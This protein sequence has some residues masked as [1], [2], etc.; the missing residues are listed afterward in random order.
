MKHRLT[1]L[2]ALAL[3]FSTAHADPARKYLDIPAQPLASA[4]DS[5]AKQSGLQMLFDR[6][7]LAGK[8]SAALRG[9][10]T[11]VEAARKLLAGS[12]LVVEQTGDEAVSIRPPTGEEPRSA[13][14]P[15]VTVA[16]SAEYDATDPYNK[17]YAT[18]DS[19]AAT[20][21]DTPIIET[22]VSVVPR[23]VMD[24]QKT[25]RIKDALENVS[26]V[27]AQ[28]TL[29]GGNG[30]IIRGFRNGTVYRN[31]L[32]TNGNAFVGFPSEFDAGNLQSIDVL[33]GPA[34]VLFGRIEPGGLINI[35][36]TVGYPLLFA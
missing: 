13:T 28:P 16:G 10:Y 21:T 34:A 1:L 4:M 30:F 22:P 5:L 12:G 29:G 17:S 33:K 24:D 7:A 25:T 32:L 3:A 14:L 2:G 36:T 23:T 31:G 9:D 27:R 20:K 8:R 26:G 11:G 15:A 18:P 6:K 19:F 35:T